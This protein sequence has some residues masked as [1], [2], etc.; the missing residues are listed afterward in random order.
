MSFTIVIS[1]R[2]TEGIEAHTNS[3]N[4]ENF[5][6][7]YEDVW[8]RL[9]DEKNQTPV[10]IRDNASLHTLI[11]STEFMKSKGIKWIT[12][13]LYSPQLNEAEKIIGF[14]KNKLRKVW[15]NGKPISIAAL[16]EILDQIT[17]DIWIDI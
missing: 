10:I 8:R 15:L 12:I 1:S 17:P 5:I 11:E 6:W 9:A 7:F 2:G 13:T 14:I 4:S 16:K 3:N